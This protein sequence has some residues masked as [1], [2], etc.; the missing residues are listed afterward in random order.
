[1][2]PTGTP[3]GRECR[4]SEW[5]P[6]HGVTLVSHFVKLHHVWLRRQL[7][8]GPTTQRSYWGR[9]S[10]SSNCCTP[11]PQ[12]TRFFT[13]RLAEKAVQAPWL[14]DCPSHLLP[15]DR[16]NMIASTAMSCHPCSP[17]RAAY[18]ALLLGQRVSDI[19]SLRPSETYP[20]KTRVSITFVEGVMART[21]ACKLGVPIVSEAANIILEAVTKRRG[22]YT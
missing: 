16:V 17:E 9:L 18:L 15:V 10:R 6:N 2:H 20:S 5:V 22:R 1:V 7:G 4:N 12:R 13:K 14:P 11:R 21:G 8:V 3:N 19:L